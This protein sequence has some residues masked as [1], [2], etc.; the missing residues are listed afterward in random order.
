VAGC[1]DGAGRS[2]MDAPILL[3]VD[4]DPGAL[5]ALSGDLAEPEQ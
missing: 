3:V 2:S 4:E 5:E 1:G